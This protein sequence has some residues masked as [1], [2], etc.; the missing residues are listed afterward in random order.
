MLSI[1]PAQQSERENYKL[2][3]GSI[4]PRPIALV[5]TLSPEGVLNAAPFSYFNIVSSKPP[6]VSIAIQRRGGKP[7]DTARNAMTEGAFV[8]HITDTSYL[9]QM[10]QTAA[11]LPPEASEVA[12]AELTQVASEAIAVPGL[13]EARIRME[14]VLE[15]ALPLGETSESPTTDLLLGRIVRFH[16]DASLYHEGR[17]DIVALDPVSRL[18]GSDYARLGEV[19]SLP[20]PD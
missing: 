20:R 16:I 11:N 1:D 9:E 14:C 12:L 6:L 2:L 19:I 3:I 8:V 7:K 18:A 5:T 10:N 15:Q 13:A 17:I 4:V